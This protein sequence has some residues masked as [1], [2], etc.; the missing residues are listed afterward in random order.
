MKLA[1]GTVQFGLD[2]GISNTSGITSAK[3]VERILEYANHHGVSLLDTAPLYG[4]SE[5]VLGNVLAGE[6]EGI[7]TKTKLF[8]GELL[9]EQDGLS[10]ERTLSESLQSLQQK[11]V[12]SLLIHHVD[13]L[14]KPGGKYL[15]HALQSLRSQGLVRK[16][17]VSVYTGEQIDRVLAGFDID[18]IQLPVNVLDQRLIT[19]GHLAE[20]KNKRVE[21]HA[22]S[23]FLQGL[24]LMDRTTLPEFF[25]PAYQTLEKYNCFIEKQGW[26]PVEAALGF[27]C[28][29]DLVDYVVCGVNTLVQLEELVAAAQVK[30]DPGLFADFAMD[31][32]NI[33]N[34]AMWES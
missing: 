16:I 30:V 1:L 3:E 28:N 29:L 21:I 31:D 11:K 34:P 24:L 9:T 2:Y 22:R 10:L 5:E 25:I 18:I 8:P 33:L 7:I 4:N 27:V 17:G 20:L 32:S 14:L 15:F 23:V 13:D 12:Y 19:D 26:T 6:H